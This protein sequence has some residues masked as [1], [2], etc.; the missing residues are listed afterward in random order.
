MNEQNKDINDA[1]LVLIWS[2]VKK[3]QEESVQ[4]FKHSLII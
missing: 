4:P 2:T 3:L 1:K